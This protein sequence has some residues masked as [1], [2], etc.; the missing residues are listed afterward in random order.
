MVDVS[1]I[2]PAR[3]EPYLQQTID[4]LFAKAKESIEVI[5]VLDGYWP[6]PALKDNPNLVIIHKTE[7]D[8]MRSAINSAA[9]V[10]TGHFLMKCDGHCMF[11][12]GFDTILKKDCDS[13][14]LA[15]PSR[16]G[17]DVENWKPNNGKPPVEYLYMT[18]P[19]VKEDQFGYGFHGKKWTGA[20]IGPNGWWEPENRLKDKKIDEIMIW[21]GSCW[22]MHRRTFYEVDMLDTMYSY[23]MFQE[24]NE[25]AM[26]F[27][28]SGRKLIVNKNTWYAHWH[29]PT[30]TNVGWSLS[31]RLKKQTEQMSVWFWMNNKWPKRVV[32]FKWYVER[33]WPIPTW[34]KEW[35]EIKEREEAEHPEIWGPSNFQPIDKNGHNGL[36]V[37]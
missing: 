11:G 30:G 33:F 16:Y 35:E 7:A 4:D 13:D 22:F 12:E 34:P 14:T 8:G 28:L 19:Y 37:L 31:N 15:V 20:T 9:D 24:A 10:S 3:K 21:Q 17:L 5:V 2:I 29:K 23:N 25:L 27:W 32:D 26:K 1:V 6:E 36:G 18:F